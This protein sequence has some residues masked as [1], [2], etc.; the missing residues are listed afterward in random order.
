M[1]ETETV[2]KIIWECVEENRKYH[3]IRLVE[4]L[5][6]KTSIADKITDMLGDEVLATRE[7]QSMQR[8]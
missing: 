1:R 8:S 3:V 5:K 2:V 7:L 6:G 4:L